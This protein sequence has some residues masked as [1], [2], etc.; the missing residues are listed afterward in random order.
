AAFYERGGRV[1]CLGSVP[2][3]GERQGS[4]TIVSAISPPGGDFSEPVTQSSLRVAGA[5]WALDSDLAHRRHFPAVD[6]KRSYSLYMDTLD[7]WFRENVAADWPEIRKRLMAVLQKEEELQEIVQLVGIDALQDP[8]RI[9]LEVSRMI[10]E[11]FLRQS[12]FSE[13]DAS[14]PPEKQY[15]MARAFFTF[16]DLSEK[17][18]GGGASIEE[19]LQS[20][21]RGE[22]T[23]M[24]EMPAAGF[25]DG[26]RRLIAKMEKAAA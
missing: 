10:R 11:E 1:D 7:A 14:C 20:P 24:K 26:A 4:I 5:I 12:A 19:V 23:Q 6:W 15:W 17:R 8:E 2:G 21:F 22:L 9:T 3:S 18:L 16:F 13:T 25:A